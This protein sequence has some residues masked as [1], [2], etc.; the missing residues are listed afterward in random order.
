MQF[1]EVF[2][3]DNNKKMSV[4]FYLM[5]VA[6][7]HPAPID[8]QTGYNVDLNEFLVTHPNST[9]FVKVNGSQMSEVGINNG[10]ILIV[11]TLI[12]PSDGK[13][14][15]ANINSELSIKYYRKVDGIEYL[16]AQ[17]QHFFPLNI[18]GEL[19]CKVLGTVTKIIHSF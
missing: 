7:G 5:S 15:L 12:N 18:G 10:D 11:D 3:I 17:S 13:F 1:L 8:T 2:T 4:P 9:F 16:E 6:A 19:S 14:V